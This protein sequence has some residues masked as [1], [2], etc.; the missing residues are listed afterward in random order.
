MF[1]ISGK[2]LIFASKYL[3]ANAHIFNIEDIIK[4]G[5]NGLNYNDLLYSTCY[6]TPYY[7]YRGNSFL[8]KLKEAPITLGGPVLCLHCGKE[9]ITNPATMRCDY[10]ELEYG[11]EEN[12]DICSCACCGTRMWADDGVIVEPYGDIVCNNCMENECVVCERCGNIFYK[13]EMKYIDENDDG[14][15]C[16]E[17]RDSILEYQQSR[18]KEFGPVSF[19]W[20]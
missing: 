15:V 8:Q 11:Y 4:Q 13:N 14:L 9:M 10:C 5:K 16:A 6:R 1:D 2:E 3:Q 19:W 12:D 7:S 17:C 20:N 18:E